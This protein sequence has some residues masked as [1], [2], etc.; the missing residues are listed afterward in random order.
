MKFSCSSKFEKYTAL[1][2]WV[3][4]T[5][6]VWTL[7]LLAEV[8][9]QNENCNTEWDKIQCYNGVRFNEI[10]NLTHGCGCNEG[11]FGQS[12][13]P[14]GRWGYTVSNYIAPLPATAVFAILSIIPIRSV[15][16]FTATFTPLTGLDNPDIPILS[17]FLQNSVWTSLGAFIFSWILILVFNVCTFQGVHHVIVTVFLIAG[18]IYYTSVYIS[19]WYLE[20]F[21]DMVN[22]NGGGRSILGL[23]AVTVVF[24]ICFILLGMLYSFDY[25]QNAYLVWV[26]ESAAITTGFLIP[27]SELFRFDSLIEKIEDKLEDKL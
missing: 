7:P 2:G 1:F 27:L 17:S 10:R 26:F 24:V 21:W 3:A 20:T 22:L 5:V 13:C 23:T 14:D 16:V 6:F 11:I 19:F 8:F 18:I 25:H 9:N 12:E 4:L 15:W